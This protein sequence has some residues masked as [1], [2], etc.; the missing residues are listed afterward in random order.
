MTTKSIMLHHDSGHV[1]LKNH[2]NP[3]SAATPSVFAN[4][5]IFTKC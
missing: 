1:P 3:T 4:S 2:E 5:D